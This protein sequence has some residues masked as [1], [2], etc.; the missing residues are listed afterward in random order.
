MK[1]GPLHDPGWWLL[2]VHSIEMGFCNYMVHCSNLNFLTFW[3]TLLSWLGGLWFTSSGCFFSNLP[4]FTE[5]KR[6]SPPLLWFTFY[7]GISIPA[8]F[9]YRTKN[10]DTTTT[11][12]KLIYIKI[13]RKAKKSTQKVLECF[14]L[15]VVGGGNRTQKNGTSN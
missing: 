14:L 6:I 9:T 4:W 2:L 11:S 7:V 10:K 3:F 12:H 8:R 5:V 15:W 1:S 13:S